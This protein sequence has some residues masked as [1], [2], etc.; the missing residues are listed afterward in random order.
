MGYV[1]LKILLFNNS[2]LENA[3]PCKGGKRG[4]DMHKILTYNYFTHLIYLFDREN[5][6]AYLLIML[7]FSAD[8]MTYRGVEDKLCLT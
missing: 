8:N 4:V 7:K 2:F 1:I 6:R 5:I 3:L